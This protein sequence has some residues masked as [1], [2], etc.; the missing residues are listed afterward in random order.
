MSLIGAH[1]IPVEV[2]GER[3]LA[4]IFVI[5]ALG[6]PDSSVKPYLYFL[7][8][9]LVG[10][11]TTTG[12]LVSYGGFEIPSG[13][14]VDDAPVFN[15]VGDRVATVVVDN[16]EH[17]TFRCY[18]HSL[19]S[20]QVNTASTTFA[21]PPAPGME[22]QQVCFSHDGDFLAILMNNPVSQDGSTNGSTV[23]ICDLVNSTDGQRLKGVIHHVPGGTT[24]ISW[25]PNGEILVCDRA[26]TVSTISVSQ[27]S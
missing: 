19:D 11:G 10:Q 26:N 22:F 18:I 1:T 15:Q 23:M 2:G 24:N 16:S 12:E 7:S 8:P 20:A 27:H 13:S 9:E 14:S 25:A 21:V 5:T 3:L 6:A 17:P 4:P